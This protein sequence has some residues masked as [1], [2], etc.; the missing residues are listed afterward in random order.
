MDSDSDYQRQR[1]PRRKN[2]QPPQL[3][4]NLSCDAMAAQPSSRY[5]NSPR[6]RAFEKRERDDNHG[7]SAHEL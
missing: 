7:P 2:A 6:I 5:N 4:R 3:Q 1:E